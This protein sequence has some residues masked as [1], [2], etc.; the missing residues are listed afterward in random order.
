MDG[1]ARDADAERAPV[2]HRPA[3]APA[4]APDVSGR[5]SGAASRSHLLRRAGGGGEAGVA[6]DAA[7]ADGVGSPAAR[8]RA[9]GEVRLAF[10]FELFF[11]DRDEARRRAQRFPV[12]VDGE[13]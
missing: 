12:V 2:E 6:A 9:E 11:F 8:G 1:G 4:A 5:L 7:V 3:A 13:I 10:F